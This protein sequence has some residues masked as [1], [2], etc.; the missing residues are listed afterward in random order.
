MGSKSKPDNFSP[1]RKA[2]IR[3]SGGIKVA[4]IRWTRAEIL[5]VAKDHPGLLAQVDRNIKAGMADGDALAAAFKSYGVPTEMA[6]GEGIK[7]AFTATTA[8]PSQK[9]TR[10]KRVKKDTGTISPEFAAA[11]KGKKKSMKRVKPSMQA[12]RLGMTSST[13]KVFQAVRAAVG[14]ETYKRLT[15]MEKWTLIKHI[16]PNV[17]GAEAVGVIRN[18]GSK[19]LALGGGN[20]PEIRAEIDAWGKAHGVAR[21]A[22]EAL[23]AKDGKQQGLT[24]KQVAQI[25]TRGVAGGVAKTPKPTQ[26]DRT[27]R[28]AERGKKKLA[29]IAKRA[30]ETQ[31]GITSLALQPDKKSGMDKAT[32]GLAGPGLP[33]T[34]V[35]VKIKVATTKQTVAMNSDGSI[36]KDPATGNTQYE[37][38]STTVSR[39]V[40]YDK[41]TKKYLINLGK[42]HWRSVDL[43]EAKAQFEA[44]IKQEKPGKPLPQKS[45]F[46][47][48]M[49]RLSAAGKSQNIEWTVESIKAGHRALNAATKELNTK[50]AAEGKP[51]KPYV[52]IKEFIKQVFPQIDPREA[53][54][55]ARAIKVQRRAVSVAAKPAKVRK[56]GVT[57]LEPQSVETGRKILTTRERK[58]D[59]AMRTPAGPEVKPPT[60][61]ERAAATAA[62]KAG[63]SGTTMDS[64]LVVG[65]RKRAKRVAAAPTSPATMLDALKSSLAHGERRQ[66]AEMGKMRES[67][68]PGRVKKAMN[69]G[70]FGTVTPAVKKA[71]KAAGYIN[72]ALLAL[73]HLGE[74]PKKRK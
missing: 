54:S 55:M 36:K 14:E 5:S 45:A 68:K 59:I 21:A 15:P 37:S 6:S 18:V 29:E 65:G 71:A 9:R 49:A 66:L 16:L 38:V 60:K 63:I 30:A 70:V 35:Q 7:Q 2:M 69:A 34:A 10:A 32:P 24:G 25:Q 23:A 8:A 12:V 52:S 43:K 40:W 19:I 44:P 48:K 57:Q 33:K 64:S 42:G 31:A 61:R 39:P 3:G 4:G 13:G 74:T 56:S 62:M 72:I 11:A 28:R 22:D 58:R 1:S 67:F 17:Q 47:E 46:P 26:A 51:T 73:Q 41:A 53:G 27:A 50:L 20:T